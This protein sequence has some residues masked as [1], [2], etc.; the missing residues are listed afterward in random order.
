MLFRSRLT[1]VGTDAFGNAANGAF[2]WKVVPAALGA[3]APGSRGTATFTARRLLGTGTVTASAGAISGTAS[4]A[5][6][7]ARLRIR[8]LAF[9]R[10]AGGLRLEV[11]AVDGAR[12]P[13]SLAAVSIVVRRNGDR[14]VSG[15]VRT[16]PAG[17]ALLRV[18]PARGCLV[19]TVTRASAVGFLWDG[20][21]PRARYCRR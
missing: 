13:V 3:I 17:R 15:R 19:A 12:R 4:V 2:V 5:V 21:T 1:A 6:T 8:S 16:G 9:R 18:P 14:L 11:L 10:V 20:R 7:P